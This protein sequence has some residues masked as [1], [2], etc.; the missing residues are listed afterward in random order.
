MDK[1]CQIYP[2]Q[3]SILKIIVYVPFCGRHHPSLLLERMD[4]S[5]LPSHPQGHHQACYKNNQCTIFFNY[6]IWFF[7]TEQ[8]LMGPETVKM[9]VICK[10]INITKRP[11][12]YRLILRLLCLLW[13]VLLIMT[14]TGWAL[15]GTM[16]VDNAA[17]NFPDGGD[18]EGWKHY[19]NNYFEHREDQQDRCLNTKQFNKNIAWFM[20]IISWVEN[21]KGIFSQGRSP[22]QHIQ[23]HHY[24][25]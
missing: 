20:I 2:N 3:K 18:R 6:N 10:V 7:K 17:I 9:R 13:L 24:Y 25:L 23:N 21:S 1:I 16:F 15:I 19:L 8:T 14:D 4:G 11:I 22:T 5:W 12:K